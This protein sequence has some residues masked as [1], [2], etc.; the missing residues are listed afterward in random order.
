[1]VFMKD[2]ASTEGKQ[3]P[4]MHYGFIVLALIVLSVFSA[5]G[6]ARFGYT[7]ILPAMQEGL[8][9]SNTQTGALQTLNLMREREWLYAGGNVLLSVGLCM[10]AVWLGFALGMAPLGAHAAVRGGFAPLPDAGAFSGAGVR[11]VMD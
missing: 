6:L 5:L 9:L 4:A 10:I 3:A 7:S 11:R 1:M 8:H 2:E